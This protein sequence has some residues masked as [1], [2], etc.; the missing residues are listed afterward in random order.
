ML[1]SGEVMLRS[2]KS[3]FYQIRMCLQAISGDPVKAQKTRTTLASNFM[4]FRYVVLFHWREHLLSSLQPHL[5]LIHDLADAL[6]AGSD[7]AGMDPAVQ[8]DVL[9]DHFLK[10]VH[11]S[12]DGIS[13]CYGFVLIPCNSNL[14]LWKNSSKCNMKWRELNFWR[15]KKKKFSSIFKISVLMQYC[16]VWTGNLAPPAVLREYKGLTYLP[17]LFLSSN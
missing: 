13:C 1:P 3:G 5:K 10:L 2:C 7:D 14:I 4:L 12:L 8:G 11:D 16:S 6:A 9:G 17:I 15:D